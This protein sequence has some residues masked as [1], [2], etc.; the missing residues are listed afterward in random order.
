MCIPNSNFMTTILDTSCLMNMSN[1]HLKFKITNS[2]Q[3]LSHHKFTITNSCYQFSSVHHKFE[4]SH[5]H[6]P[7]IVTNS[8]SQISIS[9][10]HHK[11]SFHTF[12]TQ[13]QN[14]PN[15]PQIY[16]IN[17]SHKF[18]ITQIHHIFPQ[19]EFTS[20]INHT[21]INSNSKSQIF[22]TH[23]LVTQIFPNSSHKIDS[24]STINPLL[25]KTHSNQSITNN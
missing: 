14:G 18:R 11:L 12:I 19:H 3:K 9:Q 10:I 22:I 8:K 1:F 25:L 21:K 23:I 2:S 15:S 24:Q 20:H 4:I 6:H 13:I 17:S 5:S 7:T 16:H